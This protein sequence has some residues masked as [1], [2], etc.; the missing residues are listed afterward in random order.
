[1]TPS[2]EPFLAAAALGTIQGATEFLPV[3]ST[4]HLILIPRLLGWSHPLLNSL[5]FDVMLHF[6]TL[7]AL[8]AVFGG[9]WFKLAR[10]LA[11]P[12]SETGRFAWG[13]AIATAPALVCGALFE[14]A[15][16]ARLR[17]TLSVACWLTGGAAVLLWAE[18]RHP[19]CRAAESLSLKEAAF[20]G[21]AQVLALLPGFSRSGATISACLLLGVGRRE[22]ARYSFLL[23]APVVAAGFLWSARRL[24]THPAPELAAA[25][26]GAFAAALT[27]VLAI[28]WLLRAVPRIGYAPFAVYRFLLAAALV[29]G[30]LLG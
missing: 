28:R 4:A 5:T 13:L 26:A 6:G 7:A 24:A 12:R 3:S 21:C 9:E 20:V 25:V 22:A 17:G 14:S 11:A 2:S 8:L 1:M 30:A 27:G 18:R 23:S 19:R 15:V 16:A 29:F 10:A